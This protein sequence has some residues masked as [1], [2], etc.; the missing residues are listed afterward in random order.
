VYAMKGILIGSLRLYIRKLVDMSDIV[1]KQIMAIRATGETNM[2]QVQSVL[3]M[4]HHMGLYE[5]VC[6]IEDNKA[7]YVRFVLTGERSGK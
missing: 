3:W 5:L 4:A 6:W 2:L 7:D 1:Y